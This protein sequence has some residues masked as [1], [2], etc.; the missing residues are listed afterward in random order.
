MNEN[1]TGGFY[2]DEEENEDTTRGN[3]RTDGRLDNDGGLDDDDN[4][5]GTMEGEDEALP[6][7]G[8]AATT[9]TTTTTT[10]AASSLV[11]PND[12]VEAIRVVL[13]QTHRR[14]VVLVLVDAIWWSRRNK[15]SQ[16]EIG[17]LYEKS[18]PAI[19]E[20]YFKH[21]NWPKKELVVEFLEKERKKKEER[22]GRRRDGGGRRQDFPGAVR[23]ALLSPRVLANLVA[24]D[25][26]ESGK[27]EGVLQVV[28]LRF[29]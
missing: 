23:R 27:L 5:T 25:R 18:F 26:G 29:E 1:N 20:R 19:S 2:N 9:T 12:H 17:N 13:T 10:K 22:K 16:H 4:A 3:G 28:R 14:V 7:P 15:T 21:A 8:A 11:L 24:V 6:L